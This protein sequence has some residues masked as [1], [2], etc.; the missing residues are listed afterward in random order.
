M[1]KRIISLI[2]ATVLLLGGCAGDPQQDP[3]VT[4]A[5]TTSLEEYRQKVIA[6]AEVATY[7]AE[8][9]IEY[10]PN[11]EVYISLANRNCDYYPNYWFNRENV[12][13]ITK[14]HYDIDEIQVNIPMQTEYTVEIQDRTDW[15]TVPAYDSEQDRFALHLY[16]YMCLQGVDWQEIGQLNANVDA[17]LQLEFQSGTDQKARQ[18][19]QTLRKEYQ[20][21]A[22]AIFQKYESEYYA[23]SR[24]DIPQFGVYYMRIF[25]P[26]RGDYEE[27]VETVEFVI[28]G[29]SYSVD[30][31]QW[32]FHKTC[33]QMLL[34]GFNRVGLKQIDIAIGQ[35][36]TSPYC[37]DYAYLPTTFTFEAKED[38][39][40][41]GIHYEGTALNILGAQ[42][43]VSGQAAF[44][45]NMDTPIE[46]EKGDNV[47]MD[48]YLRDD[49]FSEYNVCITGYPV[50][51]YE[52]R[53]KAYG[54]VT[55]CLLFRW[56]TYWDSY[57]MAF[58]GIDVGAYYTYLTDYTYWLEE[59]PEAW[60]K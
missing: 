32:R 40:V 51:D 7:D 27:T 22:E 28:G 20:A 5:G 15:C 45:W 21:A 14:E 6:A 10:D 31:G 47:Q 26:E 37:G 58:K 23:L 24:E 1:K 11:R 8:P 54:M 46:V 38:L 41:T 29:K 9:L 43:T 44:F 56:D 3:T 34:D 49:Y 12:I 33:P 35:V 13:I 52:I 36:P 2:L 53:G 48:L 55:P 25:F 60:L 30:I 59:M 19:Y 4:T 50:M 42:V 18:A 39:T 17:A 16:Q 57:L